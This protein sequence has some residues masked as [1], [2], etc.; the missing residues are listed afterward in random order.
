MYVSDE[1]CSSSFIPLDY[2]LTIAL[3]FVVCK[4]NQYNT[5]VRM[6]VQKL[7]QQFG[8]K[9]TG[10]PDIFCKGSCMFKDKM[11]SFFVEETVKYNENGESVV[12]R[13]RSKV[14]VDHCDIIGDKFWKDHVKILEDE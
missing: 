6:L 1:F 5:W 4:K 9:Y 14:I 3:S 13:F 2:K 10:L 8:I 12:K 7:F 11:N